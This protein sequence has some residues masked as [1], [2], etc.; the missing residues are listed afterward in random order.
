MSELESGGV[1]RMADQFET[2]V[3]IHD[4]LT[5]HL[6]KADSEA[7]GDRMEARMEA[8]GLAVGRR[9]YNACRYVRLHLVRNRLLSNLEHSETQH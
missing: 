3:R 4:I 5:L 8:K 9:Q 2:A 6:L 7:G 1:L